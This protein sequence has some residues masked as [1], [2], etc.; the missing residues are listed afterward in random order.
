MNRSKPTIYFVREVPWDSVFPISTR[1]LAGEF[2]ADGWNVVWLNPPLMLWHMLRQKSL[3]FPD[4]RGRHV[5]ENV[6]AF[7]PATAIPFGRRFPLDRPWLAE[8]MWWGC[9][10]P[11]RELLTTND[12]PAPNLLFLSHWSAFGLRHLFPDT[13]ILYHITDRYEDMPFVP[14]T[15]RDIQ[16]DNLCHANHVVVTA[17]SLERWVVDSY[18]YPSDKVKVVIHGVLYDRF[19][20]SFVEP[21]ILCGIPRPRVVS[22]GNTSKLP[23]DGLELLAKAI[24]SMHLVLLGPLNNEVSKLDE[25]HPNIHALGAIQ[26]DDVPSFLTACDVGIVAFGNQIDGFVKGICPMKLFEYAA[27]GLPVVSTPLPVYESLDAPVWQ[28]PMGD[29]FVAAIRA[30]LKAPDA[31]REQMRSF[32]R[33]NT[34]QQRYEAV[35]PIVRSLL[36]A[37]S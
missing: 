27:A 29:A 33:R 12:V 1:M 30:A 34:W 17:P 26:P 14:K 18:G 3:D 7:T 15:F 21:S 36:Q 10:P 25:R 19:Q 32:A 11:L 28:A 16:I 20:D 4:R 13:P 24:P 8:N 6:F 37:E 23:F 2:A 5:T 31:L 35:L 9:V 22:I